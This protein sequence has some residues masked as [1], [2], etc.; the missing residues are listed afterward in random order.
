MNGE[1]AGMMMDGAPAGAETGADGTVQ[2]AAPAANVPATSTAN[3]QAGAADAP[4]ADAPQ[5][6]TTPEFA[7]EV[8]PMTGERRVVQ[9][10]QGDV[11]AQPDEAAQP[12]AEDVQSPAAPTAY[13]SDEFLQAMTLGQVDESR[14]PDALKANYIALC[15]QRQIAAMQAQQQAAMQ[16]AAAMQQPSQEA[17]PA[18]DMTA[19]YRRMREV[20]EAKARADLGLSASDLEGAE[21]G[22]DEEAQKKVEAY[23]VAVEMNIQQLARSIDE[24]QRQMVAE[25]QESQ[26]AMA[27]IVPLYQQL[28]ATEPHFAEIDQMMIGHYRRMAYADAVKVEAAMRR[29]AQG[30]PTRAD[31]PVLKEY[32]DKTRKA[33]YAKRQGVPTTPVPA[34]PPARAQPPRVE[35]AGR[36][37]AAPAKEVDWRAMR[38]MDARERNA[39]IA[40]NLR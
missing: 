26:Q 39:F 12:P 33:F 23:R 14:I 35:G 27:Q 36:V 4:A 17:Q 25:Q 40:A 22:E 16:Q 2:T 34:M 19:M 24:H 13:T 37:T 29:L 28:A 6:D 1:D 32:Y 10:A 9:F 7:I 11:T 3:V 5:T 15:Q 8:D 38:T 20:A 30:T 21:Y 31:V 18:P